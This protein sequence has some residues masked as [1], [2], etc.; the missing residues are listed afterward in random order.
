MLI[1]VAIRLVIYNSSS[2]F[3][4]SQIKFR[5]KLLLCSKLIAHFALQQ[6]C[7]WT[8]NDFSSK[9]CTVILD[10]CSCPVLVTVYVELRQLS[11]DTRLNTVNLFRP[12]YQSFFRHRECRSHYAFAHRGCIASQRANRW[13][14]TRDSNPS[15][16]EILRWEITARGDEKYSWRLR[17]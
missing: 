17:G 15:G 9:L 11:A 6:A 16:G 8:K 10:L 4:P 13:R 12:D 2:S 5:Y 1:L 14:E 7:G 3:I